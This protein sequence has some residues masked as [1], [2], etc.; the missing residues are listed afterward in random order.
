MTK[1]NKFEV[2]DL[3]EHKASGEKGIVLRVNAAAW[4]SPI[5]TGGKPAYM[6]AI[7]FGKT[8]WA[9]ENELKSCK[10]KE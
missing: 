1:K 6:V 7:G 2:G 10:E 8:E 9:A 5:D 4:G 3:V